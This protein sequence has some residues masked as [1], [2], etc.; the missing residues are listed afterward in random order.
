MFKWLASN[1]PPEK[2]AE[3]RAG[4]DGAG[5]FETLTADLTDACAGE[6]EFLFPAESST[7]QE[8]F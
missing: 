5:G 1:Y 2:A 7:A 4:R 3:S 6:G 8:R